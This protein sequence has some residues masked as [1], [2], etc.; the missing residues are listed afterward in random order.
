MDEVRPIGS[1]QNNGLK[2]FF[3][4]T[5]SLISCIQ[6]RTT[7]SHCLSWKTINPWHRQSSSYWCQQNE[8]LKCFFP[9]I[10]TSILCILMELPISHCP[11][12]KE[13]RSLPQ[14]KFI[15][16]IPNKTN[17]WNVVFSKPKHQYHVS[18][19]KLSISHCLSREKLDFRHGRSSS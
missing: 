12:W 17:G 16:L 11:S 8:K 10:K 5:K 18:Q 1:Q 6:M 14:M 9:D 13:T 7:I 3:L 15:M 19:W 2:C 4:E